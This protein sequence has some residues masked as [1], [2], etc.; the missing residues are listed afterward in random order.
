MTICLKVLAL[1][2]EMLE[3][4]TILFSANENSLILGDELCSGT[5]YESAI[6]IFVAGLQHLHSMKSSYIFATHLHEIAKY[7]EIKDI[8]TLVLKHMKVKYD[9]ENDTLIYSRK[10]EDGPGESMYG[11]EVCKSLKLPPD[12]MNNAF[13][14]REKYSTYNKSF[15]SMKPSHYNSQKIKGYC[16]KCKKELATE[17]H[18]LQHQ[19]SAN[20]DGFIGDF[21][22]NNSGNLMSLCEDCHLAF[23]KSNKQHKKTKT[24]KG[25]VLE[26]I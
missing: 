18:H 1:A 26:E 17:V 13:T 19:K 8:D 24:S 3:L 4:R 14:I 25:Y 20:E 2:V 10:L 9:H 22:K 12:F 11:L 5:E 21:H 23:H 6:S 16:E 15:L 7:D